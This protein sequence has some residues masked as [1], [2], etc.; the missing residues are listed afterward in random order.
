[1]RIL[2][3]LV[4]IIAIGCTNSK[5]VLETNCCDKNETRCDVNINENSE[6][7][8]LQVSESSVQEAEGFLFISTRG[9]DLDVLIPGCTDPLAC[10]YDANSTEDDGSC[11]LEGDSC[12]D[13]SPY[14]INDMYSGAI[15]C[16]CNG[17]CINDVDGDGVCDEEEVPGCDNPEAI[18]YDP[19]ATDNDGTCQYE[20]SCSTCILSDLNGDGVVGTMDLLVFLQLFGV[21]YE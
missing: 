8:S 15:N 11:V 6:C 13:G 4:A 14:T 3:M 16:E 5:E 19:N 10:N 7:E 1:M 17:I 18:N 20:Q 12:D 9:D 21:S 2:L